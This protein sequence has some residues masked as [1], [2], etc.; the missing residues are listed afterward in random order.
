MKNKILLFCSFLFIAN[1][2][3]IAHADIKKTIKGTIKKGILEEFAG[4]L[5]KL[6][7]L[8]QVK[9]K[10]ETNEFKLISTSKRRGILA[11]DN[12]NNAENITIAR[13]RYEP[14][15]KIFDQAIL[16]SGT[17]WLK[18][19]PKDTKQQAIERKVIINSG[20]INKTALNFWQKGLKVFP[21][22][23]N[24][25]PQSA[26]IRILNIVPKYKFSMPLSPGKYLVEVSHKDYKTAKFNII[27][28]HNQ[29]NFNVALQPQKVEVISVTGTKKADE[30]VKTDKPKKEYSLG[31]NIAFWSIFTLLVLLAIWLIYRLIKFLKQLL[32]KAWQMVSGKNVA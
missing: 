13:T 8:K 12:Y 23:I 1:L 18:A 14:G 20:V 26:R 24:T 7:G 25:R 19:Q 16:A 10:I 30:S 29:N 5:A 17:Y 11:L 27:L 6:P 28:D 22:E 3:N 4:E 9:E 31:F 21:L 32:S 15:L 2:A